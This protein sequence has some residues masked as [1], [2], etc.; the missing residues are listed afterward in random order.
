MKLGPYHAILWRHGEKGRPKVRPE[1]REVIDDAAFRRSWP[2]SISSAHQPKRGGIDD[3]QV[4]RIVM[5]VARTGRRISEIRMLDRDPLLPLDQL[6]PPSA[7]DAADGAFVAKL[8]IS[9]RRS[10]R[11]RTPCWS[12]PRSLRSSVSSSSGP[13]PTSRHAGRPA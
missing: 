9:K 13:T 2:T 8:H 7:Q 3:E 10:S 6:T 1:R 4:M 12:T 11:L 5:L